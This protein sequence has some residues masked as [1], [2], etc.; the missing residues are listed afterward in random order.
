[1]IRIAICDDNVLSLDAVAAQID[2]YFKS[3]D[4]P[5]F[6]IAR[7]TSPRQLLED[8]VSGCRFDIV[9]LDIIMPETLGTETA[10]K[11]HLLDPNTRIVF[12]TISHDYAVDAYDIGAV[13][14]LLKPVSD[15]ALRQAM[16]RA[17][18]CDERKNDIRIVL[19]MKNSV[20]QSVDC[21][22]IFYIESIGYRRMVY[23]KKGIFEETRQTLSALLDELERLS[24]GKFF[25]PYRGYIVN[26]DAIDTITPDHIVMK[27]GS[28]ILIKRGDYRRI[29]DIFFSWTF[30]KGAGRRG[31]GK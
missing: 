28:S 8:I 4:G 31:G 9:L 5:A 16:D 18:P 14:Y 1:M 11:L 17:M 13:H 10:R 24:P 29:R 15:I 20:V 27:E 21:D 26:L 30:N 25:C 19:H 22:D 7:Y 23:T 12:M 2:G 6:D 3:S